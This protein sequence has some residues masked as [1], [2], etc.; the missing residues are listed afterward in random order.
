MAF[1]LEPEDDLQAGIVIP[2]DPAKN[3]SVRQNNAFNLKHV[4][5]EGSLGAGTKG[6]AIFPDVETGI[7]AGINQLKLDQSRGLSLGQFAEKY[8]P[9]YENPTWASDVSNALGVSLDTPLHQVPLDQLARVVAKRESSTVLPA[10]FERQMQ[11]RGGN[12]PQNRFVFND[13]GAAPTQN[14][15]R[16][17]LEGESQQSQGKSKIIAPIDPGF[18]KPIKEGLGE[19]GAAAKDLITPSPQSVMTPQGQQQPWAGIPREAMKVLSGVSAKPLTQGWGE[20]LKIA[21]PDLE[22]AAMAGAPE[23]GYIEPIGT[24]VG[25]I[26]DAPFVPLRKGLELFHQYMIEPHRE[27]TLKEWSE[28]LQSGVMEGPGAGA[29]EAFAPMPSKEVFVPAMEAGLAPAYLKLIGN[30]VGLLNQVGKEAFWKYAPDIFFKPGAKGGL[31]VPLHPEEIQKSLAGMS[32]AE[33]AEMAR[34]YPQFRDVMTEMRIVP[35]EVRPVTPGEG[36][37]RVGASALPERT[38]T[39]GPEVPEPS[40]TAVIPEP[41]ATAPVVPEKPIGVSPEPQKAPVEGTIRENLTVAPDVAKSATTELAPDLKAAEKVGG[42]FQTA[43]VRGNPVEQEFI[44]EPKGVELKNPSAINN[45][46]KIPDREGWEKVYKPYGEQGKG[47]Y[48]S[49]PVEKPQPLTPEVEAARQRGE[50]F[51]DDKGWWRIEGSSAKHSSQAAAE[52]TASVLEKWKVP[53]SEKGQIGVGES[54]QEKARVAQTPEAKAVEKTYEDAE[55]Q[56]KELK[57]MKLKRVWDRL[58]VLTTDTSSNIKKDLITMAG[59]QGKEAVMRHDLARGASSKAQAIVEENI[60]RIY[61]GLDKHEE[62]ILN[63][64]LRA[65]RDVTIL[66]YKPDHMITGGYTK[67]K[68]Q[69]YLDDVPPKVMERVREYSKAMEDNLINMKDAGLLNEKQY[70]ELKSKGDYLKTNYIQHMDPDRTSFTT[71][72]KKITVPDSGIKKLGSGSE[73][74]AEM[75]SRLLMAE[76]VGRTQARIF[77]NK[78]NEALYQY[79]KDNPDNPFGIKEAKI[80]KKTK[81]KIKPEEEMAWED[82]PADYDMTEVKPESK[83]SYRWDVPANHTEVSVMQDGKRIRMVMPDKYA[84]EWVQSDPM[85]SSV[86]TNIIGWASGSK[87][88]KTYATGLNPGFAL[89]NLPRDIAHIWLVT[90]EYSKFSPKFLGQMGT[91]LKD[92]WQDTISRKGR[93]KDYI[94]EGGGMNFLTQQGQLKLGGNETLRNL[95]KWLGWIGETS[96][97][98]TRLAVRERAIKNG[99]TPEEA[100]ATARGYLDFAQGGSFIKAADSAIPYLNASIQGT[101]MLINS[102]HKDPATF[103]WKV[104]QVGA[105]ATGLYIANTSI[106]KDTWDQIPEKEK[107]TNWIVTTPLSYQDKDGNKKYLY[108]RIAKDQGQRIFASLFEGLMG[109]AMGHKVDAT[110]IRSAI[111]DFLPI[112]P[113]EKLPPAF[114][115]MLGYASNKDFW[116]NQEVWRGPKVEDRM[117]YNKFTHPALKTVGEYTNLSPE[118]LGYALSQFVPPSNTYVSLVSGGLRKMME[119]LPEKDKKRTTEEIIQQFPMVNKIMRSTDPYEKYKKPIE[120]A[121][122][123]ENTRRYEQRL[124]VERIV[125]DNAVKPKQERQAPINEYLKKQKPE[126]RNRLQKEFRDMQAYEGIPDRRWWL[127]LRHMPAESRAVVYFDRIKEMPGE[128]RKPFE[129]QAMKL[130][131]IY[132]DAFAEKLYRLKKGFKK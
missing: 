14:Q 95:Q 36:P 24:A 98:W 82:V 40:V 11:V 101:R 48:Y 57:S 3:I 91:D 60:N 52:K 100:T 18:L 127:N 112:V 92:V 43:D 130:P 119:D 61:K 103:M 111:A 78:A 55:T 58:K 129:K 53:E 22:T 121:K 6:F 1:V 39:P 66:D 31:P 85:I 128:E 37:A 86:A 5:Q 79:V 114:M 87:I 90:G 88:L 49:R 81:G 15:G 75:N 104:A 45:I 70:N 64:A 108:F 113:T 106:N 28:A 97:I 9:A 42:V 23:A 122:I 30:G 123:D 109:G 13:E 8:A 118:R 68:L 126:D 107:V 59:T 32:A 83:V 26:I 29:P 132:S 46:S 62:V 34:K 50:V 67:E 21:Y 4:G 102:A 76:V 84:R 33:Q 10:G 120:K 125:D 124:E 72:G 77:K 47:Y 116:R 89:T 19:V 17:I 2:G 115:A 93:Y 35:E 131:G 73:Q 80:Y 44:R 74:A 69:K 27:R 105:L 96:E 63:R 54:I 65:N 99:A 41:K 51:K 56:L 94:D 16:Y 12:A 20:A 71:G 117:E 7:N 110:Q 38:I 25:K